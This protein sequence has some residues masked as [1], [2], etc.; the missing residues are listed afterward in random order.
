MIYAKYDCILIWLR[1][2]IFNKIIKQLKSKVTLE[3]LRRTVLKAKIFDI[4]AGHFHC[5][6]ESVWVWF[7]LCYKMFIACWNFVGIYNLHNAIY[8]SGFRQNICCRLWLFSTQNFIFCQCF[9]EACKKNGGF[10]RVVDTPSAF[11]SPFFIQCIYFINL[12]FIPLWF[13]I[14]MNSVTFHL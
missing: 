14:V 1:C 8:L 13:I 11:I 5:M 12:G 10:T 3:N 2:Q 7:D 9:S 4:V 6:F